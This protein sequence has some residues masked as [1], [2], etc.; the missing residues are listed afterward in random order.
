MVV[1]G[2][3]AGLSGSSIFTPHRFALLLRKQMHVCVGTFNQRQTYANK[4]PVMEGVWN[5]VVVTV[6]QPCE[7]MQSHWVVY[8]KTGAF[9]LQELHFVKSLRKY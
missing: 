4:T 9:V 5:S 2:S 8:F 6:A 7:C 3:K 1:L